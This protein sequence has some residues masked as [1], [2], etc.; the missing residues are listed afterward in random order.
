MLGSCVF[1]LMALAATLSAYVWAA[2]LPFMG[3]LLA[4]ASAPLW[5]FF[6]IFLIPAR[7]R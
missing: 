4:L 2:A 1:G 3:A 7:P 5:L 6:V